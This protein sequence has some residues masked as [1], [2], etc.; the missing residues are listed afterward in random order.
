MI[1]PTAVVDPSAEIDSDVVV[2]LRS[3]CDQVDSPIRC[4]DQTMRVDF[5]GLYARR[6]EKE[7]TLFR[8]D[9]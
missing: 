7:L 3:K 9:T 8:I 4:L 6:E 1:H 2:G 5:E